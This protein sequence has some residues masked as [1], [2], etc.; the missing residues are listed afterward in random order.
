MSDQPIADL[1]N[2]LAGE[3]AEAVFLDGSKRFVFVRAMPASLLI[4]DYMMLIA[5]SESAMLA[6][7]CLPLP[8]EAELPTGW[9]NALADESHELLVDTAERL[10]FDRGARQAERQAKRMKGLKAVETK[11]ID[12]LRTSPRQP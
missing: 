2:V 9:I 12:L 1:S 5:E 7:V 8:G 11:A 3:R 6:R 4:T 10:N